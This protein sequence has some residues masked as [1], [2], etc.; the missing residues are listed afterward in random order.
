MALADDFQAVVDSLPPDWTQ[1]ELDLRISD[2]ER[3]VEAATLLA[4]IN[5]MPYSKHDWHWRLRVAHEFGH[6]AAPRDRAR[7]AGA[8]R[9]RRASPGELA[10]RE[11]RTGRVEVDAD[12]G[13]ARVG[14]PGVPPAPR[15]S[16]RW[17]AWRCTRPTC[18]S[19]RRSRARCAPPATR[20]CA[21]TTPRWRSSTSPRAR[22]PDPP[23]GLPSVGFY[24]HTDQD[25]RRRAEAAGYDLVVPRSRMNREAVA[26]R[27]E[28][29]RGLR[30]AVVT[31]AS[32]GIGAATAAP[33]RARRAGG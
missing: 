29:A 30:L 27:R 22:C 8:A 32:S 1:L 19:A 21:A 16:R 5:A 18:C 24:L 14:A 28:A 20:W 10:L 26:A 7:H 25:T 6:A 3:Y 33:A 12:V 23:G 17:P 9:R 11:A 31:G 4:Q 2:E 13:P 15:R